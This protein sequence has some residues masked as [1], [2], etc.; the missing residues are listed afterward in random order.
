[1]FGPGPSA[2]ILEF[3]SQNV[4]A[5]TRRHERVPRHGEPTYTSRTTA[6]IISAA[7]RGSVREFPGGFVGTLVQAVPRFANS[8]F[9]FPAARSNLTCHETSDYPARN[10]G[11]LLLQKVVGL[12]KMW[13]QR[14]SPLYVEWPSPPN[15]SLHL[16][17][18][19]TRFARARS[20]PH[21]ALNLSLCLFVYSAFS[22][23]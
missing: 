16:F 22:Y 23:S 6:V 5:E 9:R 7:F 2:G 10:S 19:I 1:M 18:E 4:R 15:P 14:G 17:H 20:F 21:R 3:S 11:R 8:S 12:F 13:L